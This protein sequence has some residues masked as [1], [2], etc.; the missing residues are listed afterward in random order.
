MVAESFKLPIESRLVIAAK[1]LRGD[2]YFGIF[3]SVLMIAVC[4]G[5]ALELS[6][7]IAR[8]KGNLIPLMYF[9]FFS[10]FIFVG[11]LVVKVF[12]FLTRLKRPP[13]WVGPV[14][15]DNIE[16]GEEKFKP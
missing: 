4:V 15:W 6:W 8:G 7:E 16:T 5:V 12:H 13:L 1:S 10:S 9:Y 11:Y 3:V 14:A 2:E